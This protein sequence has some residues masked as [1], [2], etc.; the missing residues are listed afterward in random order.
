MGV[1]NHLLSQ[2]SHMRNAVVYYSLT[3]DCA[4]AARM[5]SEGLGTDP[6]ELVCTKP[7]P[8]KGPGKFLVGGAAASA[9]AT[10]ELGPVSFDAAACDLV[11][12]VVPIWAGKPAAAFNTFL[13]DHDLEG[14]RVAYVISSMSGNADRCAA[15]LDA[16]A[17]GAR[18]VG[19]LSLV[20]PQKMDPEE[21]DATLASFAREVGAA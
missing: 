5:L 1:E 18:R 15:D 6:V 9:N 11:F 19:M 13:R 16:K 7:Y 2:G 3:G 20:S 14:K 10:P 12:L 21:L 4:L 17:K 8:A